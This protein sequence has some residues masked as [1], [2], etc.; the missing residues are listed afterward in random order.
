M[1]AAA[2]AIQ[3]FSGLRT[4]DDDACYTE[5][6]TM[7]TTLVRSISDRRQQVANFSSVLHLHGWMHMSSAV[8]QA[9]EKLTCRRRRH[10]VVQ[11]L[12]ARRNTAT[13]RGLQ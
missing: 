11:F 9:S 12:G 5:S 2:R 13:R 10:L 1:D 7:H 3:G 8:Q 6:L 4:T